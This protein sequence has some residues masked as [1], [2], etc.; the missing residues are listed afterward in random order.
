MSSANGGGGGSSGGGGGG[1][2]GVRSEWC[3]LREHVCVHEMIFEVVEPTGVIKICH[4]QG[5]CGK[6]GL[7]LQAQRLHELFR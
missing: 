5:Q 4:L 1:G 2:G 7:M 3:W 6:W